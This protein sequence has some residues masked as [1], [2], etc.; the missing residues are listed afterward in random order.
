MG[1]LHLTLPHLRRLDRRFRKG[2]RLV[3]NKHRL[4]LPT[5]AAL[6]RWPDFVVAVHLFIRNKLLAVGLLPV[7][8]G[9]PVARSVG[10][11]YR[12]LDSLGRV[13]GVLRFQQ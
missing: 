4:V 10:Q 7:L 1:L 6:Q 13:R 5:E 12:P 2:C 11:A 3:W 8:G 9:Q